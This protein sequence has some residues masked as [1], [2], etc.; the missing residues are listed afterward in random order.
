MIARRHWIAFGGVALVIAMLAVRVVGAPAFT[1]AY[2]HFNAAVRLAQGDGLTDTYLWT[3]LGAPER[4]SSAGTFPSHLYWMPAASLIAGLSMGL[5]G[6]AGDHQVAQIPSVFMV[7]GMGLV[8][9]WLG[10]RLGGSARTAWLA[11]SI[12]LLNGFFVRYW[13]AIE[14]FTPYAFFGSLALLC[15][16]VGTARLRADRRS[17]LIWMVC[18]ALCGAGHLTRND[19]LLL[20]VVAGLVAIGAAIQRRQPAAALLP[21]SLLAA[22]YL[23][24]MGPWMLRNLAEVGSP[25]PLGGTQAIWFTEYNELF[26]FPPDAN[27]ARLMEAGLFDTRRDAISSNLM[28]FIA[29]EGL[30]V[31]TPLMLLGLWRRRA[32]PLIVP[33]ALYAL[34]LHLAMT[35]VFPF[36]G[37]RGGLFHSAAA[38]IP[39]WA[40]LGVDG[41]DAAI[42]WMA[43][44]RRWR[45]RQARMVFGI[46]LVG[47]AAVL[48]LSIATRGAVAPYTPDTIPQMYRALVQ[49]LPPDSR[50]LVNDPPQLYYFTGFGGA[51]LPNE[52]PD[53]I[54][55]IAARYAITH[56]LIE[57]D[58]AGQP[59]TPAPFASIIS[60]VP[61]FLE[62]VPLGMDSV[63]LY[64][65]RPPESAN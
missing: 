39:F 54:P 61:D 20:S 13:G 41:L 44:K 52:T 45:V 35:F 36:P 1:D 53:I 32:H 49:A 33:F 60:D 50:I 65:I 47:C 2:Y 10:Y 22:G 26:N 24:V 46:A 43:R 18:G 40:A 3:Y 38:L 30:V 55:T 11:G 7:A 16:G 63:R 31:M 42:D 12:S 6:A 34:G 23:L 48:T 57:L 51:V 19:G 14:T 56:V 5:L 28:T 9:F 15:M 25:L 62:P 58:G 37:Y 27:P 29:V 8:G 17:P 59:L 64:A 21:V 4:I